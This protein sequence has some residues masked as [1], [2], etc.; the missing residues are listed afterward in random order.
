ML[1]SCVLWERLSAA[2]IAPVMGEVML[3][4]ALSYAFPRGSGGM[5]QKK[6]WDV[7]FG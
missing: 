4:F 1:F 3:F 5:R 6:Q 2:K 7:D